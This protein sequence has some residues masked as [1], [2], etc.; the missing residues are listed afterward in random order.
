MNFI[1]VNYENF[2]IRLEKIKLNSGFNIP[3]KPKA[4]FYNL[5]PI[6]KIIYYEILYRSTYAAEKRAGRKIAYCLAEPDPW[7]IALGYLMW[8]GIVQGMTW[9]MVKPLL[10]NCLNV[11]RKAGVAP[12]KNYKKQVD[13]SIEF[14]FSWT[15][16][17]NNEKKMYDMF[18][19]LKREYNKM[20]EEQR[21]R[22][23]ESQ[24]KE[25]L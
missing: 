5:S 19:G 17:S 8:Q 12:G 21:K 14:G 3:V 4:A 15:I 6:E 16:Y 7:L 9:G 1:N 25:T 13:S 10:Q 22:I 20:T 2:S 11:L 23:T 18:V 24:G